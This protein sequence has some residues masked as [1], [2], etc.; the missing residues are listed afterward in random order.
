MGDFLKAV[1]RLY[2]FDGRTVSATIM[3]GSDTQLAECFV[4]TVGRSTAAKQ[5]KL[6]TQK[7]LFSV[8][9]KKEKGRERER[10]RENPGWGD[11]IKRKRCCKCRQKSREKRLVHQLKKRFVEEDITQQTHLTLSGCWIPVFMLS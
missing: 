8:E 3:D 7:I 5:T 11:E 2:L 4:L 6:Y 1:F 10:E 9:R